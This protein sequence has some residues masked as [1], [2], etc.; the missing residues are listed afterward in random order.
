M[1]SNDCITYPSR[2]FAHFHCLLHPLCSS[3]I[4]TRGNNISVA[5]NLVKV[6]KKLP[7]LRSLV[8]TS[9]TFI[10]MGFVLLLKFFFFHLFMILSTVYII[11]NKIATL[12]REYFQIE[13]FLHLHDDSIAST[14]L[15]LF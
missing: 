3:Q 14:I 15:P 9:P 12:S 10:Y 2:Q 4:M 1:Q 13:T 6:V 11:P 7:P 5:T 8:S